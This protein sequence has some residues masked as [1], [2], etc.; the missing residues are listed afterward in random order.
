MKNFKIVLLWTLTIL[1]CL[2]IYNA[3]HSTYYRYQNK[4]GFD[5]DCEKYRGETT[6]KWWNLY[7][8]EKCFYVGTRKIFD[9]QPTARKSFIALLLGLSV[10][11][12]IR[13]RQKIS[14]ED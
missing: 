8:G 9:R 14:K 6:I 1:F 5:F 7:D 11:S 2:T 3:G 10:F 12:T 13:L 4:G